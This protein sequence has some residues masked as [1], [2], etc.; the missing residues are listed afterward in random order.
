MSDCMGPTSA[1]PR[2]RRHP[3]VVQSPD[4]RDGKPQLRPFPSTSHR[5]SVPVSPVGGLQ[6]R[7]NPIAPPRAAQALP[8]AARAL[9]PAVMPPPT[10]PPPRDPR[11]AGDEEQ[12]AVVSFAHEPVMLAEVVS[13]LAPAPDGILVDATVGGGGHAAAALDA[14]PGLRLVG[15]DRDPDAVA[16]AA[17]RLARFGPR[18]EVRHDRFD[19]MSDL[20][21]GD[22]PVTAVLF[23]LGV[24]ST[25]L[26]IAGRGFSYRH[27]GPLDMRMDRTAS[28]TAADV[29]NGYDEAH[30]AEVLAAN[31]DERFARRIAAAIV[32]GRPFQRTTELAAV[33]RDAI[34]AAA[35][36][37]GGH[38]AT[39]TFQALRI[40]VNDELAVLDRALRTAIDLLAPGGRLAVLTYHSGED[41]LV[42]RILREAERGTSTAPP[43]GLPPPPG[44]VPV[45]RLLHRGG[46]RPGPD[47]LRTNRRAA[48]ARLRA[49]EKLDD[50]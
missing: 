13:L 22:E 26:D 37:R 29:V 1:A 35:R 14:N 4:G 18:A 7:R 31:A 44:A 47:E 10:A 32:A 3:A 16:A 9:H 8:P 40:E 33:V 23:D 2:C 27:D 42:K 24:S 11:G 15:Y 46:R 5:S 45:L 17:E 43:P 38:P 39:R 50:R 28:F 25:Q 19:A 36:R 41:R 34:P 21:G 48:S 30:L 20:T 6:N 12:G 49:A